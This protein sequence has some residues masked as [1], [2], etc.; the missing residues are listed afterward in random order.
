MTVSVSAEK[1]SERSG[2]F[3]WDGR[4]KLFHYSRSVTERIHD[5]GNTFHVYNTANRYGNYECAVSIK[6]KDF[7]VS[8][9]GKS[10][11][12]LKDAMFNQG[13]TMADAYRL[14]KN[15]G[16]Q[17]TISENRAKYLYQNVKHDKNPDTKGI[18]QFVRGALLHCT[19]Q[20]DRTLG[21]CMHLAESGWL[22][23]DH[24]DGYLL[25]E[26]V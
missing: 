11:E 18:R 5:K 20:K 15:M 13:D 8:V 22:S 6:N 26:R 7:E 24:L 21:D 14:L 4:G 17:I 1:I 10:Y 19:T 12:M 2:L 16:F 25:E 23:M 3:D 9:T